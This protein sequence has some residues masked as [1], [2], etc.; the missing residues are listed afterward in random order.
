M[1]I[2][3]E[4]SFTN[5]QETRRIIQEV[6]EH[7]FE[8]V[9]ST[10]GPNGRYVVV[11]QLNR[12]KVTK[13]G[14]SVAKALDFNESRKNMI[15]SIITEPA[16]KTDA[17]VGDGTTTTVFMTYQFYQHFNELLTFK[18][19]RFI[20]SLVKK[21]VEIIA[22]YV[23]LEN[24]NSKEF[25][26][27][28]MTS[29]N[30]EEEI[31]NKVLEIYS[32]SKSPNITLQNTPNL[33][34]DEVVYTKEILFDGQF[35]IDEMNGNGKLLIQPGGVHLIV[36]DKNIPMITKDQVNAILDKTGKIPVVI[37]ARNFNPDAINQIMAYNN[38]LQYVKFIPYSVKAAGSLGTQVISNLCSL[39]GMTP[40]FEMDEIRNKES[41]NVNDVPFS[42][43][44]NGL[45]FN[46]DGDALV[47]SRSEELLVGLEARYDTL[48]ILDK[49]TV[50]GTELFRRIGRLRGNNVTIRVTGTVPSEA[51]ERYYRYEDVMKAARTG[52]EFG[53]LPGIGYG[54]LT[55]AQELSKEMGKQNDEQFNTLLS[56]FTKVLV[57][58]YEHLTGH[59]YE[60][61]K[62]PVYIDL[63]TGEESETPMNVF[64]NAAATMTALT[65]A[66]STA[67][68]LGKINNI[69]GK[70]NS[71]Y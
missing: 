44:T 30:Y 24:V 12:P 14:V 10:M 50:I 8:S 59:V 21:T 47:H 36:V 43:K 57:S 61:T 7:A 37:I 53:V 27:M 16:I 68:T 20:D 4:I 66:W 63:V 32:T 33:P 69:M 17:A 39:F 52:L 13:D 60:S 25:Y 46:K 54:Y 41:L 34:E 56:L 6:V 2:L 49:Q 35:P 18:N 70:S 23:K 22:R 9:C 48:S 58:Q 45:E 5:Q 51:T 38:Q 71:K 62:T 28:L 26:N 67:K 31:V 11:N 3:S 65:G 55:A 64:D 15:A 29:S 40:I 1:S 42:L 19:V